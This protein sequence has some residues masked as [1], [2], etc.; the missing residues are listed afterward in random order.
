MKYENDIIIDETA[1]DVEWLQQPSLMMR[2]TTHEAKIQYELDVAKSRLSLIQSELDQKI[3]TDPESF[4][5]AKVTEGAVMA[6]LQQQDKYKE[7]Q[8]EVHQV[9]FEL[10]VAKG[11]VKAF[12]QRKDALENLVKLHG[13]QYFAGPRIPRELSN[14]VA[15]RTE[16]QMSANQKIAQRI[17][18]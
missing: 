7:A 8:A 2:Y 5:I 16:L 6:V 15:R 18:K 10:N 14:E 4:D 11:A 1:L 13:Q 3:R 12:A 17:R 9:S